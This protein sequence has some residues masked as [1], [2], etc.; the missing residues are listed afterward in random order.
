VIKIENSKRLLREGFYLW[1][2][3]AMQHLKRRRKA[4]DARTKWYRMNIHDLQSQ[5]CAYAKE[6]LG[7]SGNG[8]NVHSVFES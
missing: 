8:L 3:R 5:R 2:E 7:N 4:I 1:K 6:M